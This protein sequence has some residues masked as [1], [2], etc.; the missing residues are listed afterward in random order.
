MERKGETK[1]GRYHR[2]WFSSTSEYAISGIRPSPKLKLTEEQSKAV[3]FALWQNTPLAAH[4]LCLTRDVECN[5][6]AK[7]RRPDLRPTGD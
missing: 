3:G 7:K 4:Q 1:K 6:P 2:R 5:E